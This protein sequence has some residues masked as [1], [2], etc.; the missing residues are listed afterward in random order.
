MNETTQN[1][2]LIVEKP[3]MVE[4]GQPIVDG[5][6]IIGFIA[7]VIFDGR[8]E[9]VL[10]EPDTFEF[11]DNMENISDSVEN[12]L[13]LFEIAIGK[14]SESVKHNWKELIKANER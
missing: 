9:V 10:W 5:D 14:A 8:A 11:K 1:Y 2:Y 6:V 13:E 3:E 4:I 12:P 7:D